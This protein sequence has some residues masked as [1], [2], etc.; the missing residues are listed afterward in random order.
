ME[1]IKTPENYSPIGQPV[2]YAFSHPQAGTFVFQ[3]A[4]AATG[5][6][7][8]CKR[9]VA[10]ASGSF[11]IAP[12]L[13]QAI[14]YNPA[15]GATGF[16]DSSKRSITVTIAA[17]GAISQTRTYLHRLCTAQ[18]GILTTLPKTRLI[19]AGECDEIT[20][21][22][23][24]SCTAS[25][26]ARTNASTEG[27]TFH[28]SLRGLRTFRLNTADYPGAE[29]ISVSFGDLG[30]VEYLVVPRPH[31]ACRLAW[32]STEGSIEHYTFPTQRSVEVQCDKSRICDSDGYTTTESRLERRTTL[33]SAYETPQMLEALAEILSSPVVWIAEGT[34]YTPVDILTTE[35][36]TLRPETMQ[37]FEITLRS[38]LK[39]TIR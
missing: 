39:T 28:T 14:R 13:R 4:D 9:F 33:L 8:G 10:T 37:C 7:L 24:Q 26:I 25:V 29:A 1:F 32:V 5:S 31:Q 19:A 36:C 2:R 30:E 6:L 16:V 20:L 38:T 15:A 3:I 35:A 11:D 18:P 12:Y 21:L 17:E 22:T 34:A 27:E 23:S